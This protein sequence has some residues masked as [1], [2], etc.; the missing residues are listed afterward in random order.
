VLS[1]ETNTVALVG[2]YFNNDRHS[3]VQTENLKYIYVK[4]IIFLLLLNID[5]LENRSL[6]FL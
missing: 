5:C 4:I 6:D 2:L 3:G 1:V